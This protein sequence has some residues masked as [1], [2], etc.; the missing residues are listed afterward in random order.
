[1][2]RKLS[3]LI[4]VVSA[5][6]I[7]AVSVSSASI[8]SGPITN[9]ANDHLY[10][11]LSPDI[12]TNCEAEATLMGGHLVTINDA[13]ENMWL[14]DTFGSTQVI[15]F[16]IGYNDSETEGIW[17]W[18]S[19]ESPGFENW[20]DNQPDNWANTN[21]DYVGLIV[22]EG[23]YGFHSGDW[24]DGSTAVIHAVVEVIPEPTTLSLLAIGSFALLRRRCN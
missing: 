8:V 12:W 24:N 10:Y 4:L 6:L 9:P 3:V 18:S 16:W 1:M 11:L 15:Q 23:L 17:V 5:T 21:E 14:L 2:Y 13:D 22:R 19:G 7:W 20:A